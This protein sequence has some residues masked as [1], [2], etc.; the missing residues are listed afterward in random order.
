MEKVVLKKIVGRLLLIIGTI[1][2]WIPFS[3]MKEETAKEI[4]KAKGYPFANLWD[5]I[6]PL[7]NSQIDLSL[8]IPVYNNEKYIDKCLSSV[9]GQKTQYAYEVICID[10]GSK[11]RSLKMLYQ[12]QQKYPEQLKVYSQENQG[13]SKTRNRGL[14]LSMGR[15]VGFIDNDDTVSEDYVETLLNIAYKQNVEIVQTAYKNVKPNGKTID[16]VSHGDHVIDTSNNEDV[17]KYT[18]GWIWGGILKREIFNH[19][20]FPE[21]F[22]YEDMI[23]RMVIIRLSKHIATVGKP[24]Y[25]YLIHDTNASKTVWKSSNIKVVDELWLAIQLSEYSRTVLNLPVDDV[26]YQVLVEE[27][28]V[29]LWGRTKGMPT[30][31]RKAIFTMASNYLYSLSYVGNIKD[32]L[33]KKIN[34]T[35]LDRNFLLWNVLCRAKSLISM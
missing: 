1:I 2:K 9:L 34:N 20:R 24:M 35:L 29:M 33:Y 17:L 19:I 3:K 30:K 11:D 5:E 6:S 7:Q 14:T 21:G 8:I 32:C 27:F 22:W 28:T 12:W 31:V 18:Q 15:Y 23:T 13:I 10:D 4:L 26:L 16:I 25:F